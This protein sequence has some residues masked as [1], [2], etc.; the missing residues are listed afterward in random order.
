M[1]LNY[2]PH[3]HCQHCAH[4]SLGERCCYCRHTLYT[5]RGA[6]VGDTN[7]ASERVS[8]QPR[9]NGGHS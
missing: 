8:G 3:E 1:S 9:R 5:L 6:N 7:V 2:W 4:L